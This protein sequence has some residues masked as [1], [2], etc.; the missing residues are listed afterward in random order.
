M[1]IKN[2]S[3]ACVFLFNLK[4]SFRR[5]RRP[6]FRKAQTHLTINGML[7]IICETNGNVSGLV[8]GRGG[9]HN[10]MGIK[11]HGDR[12]NNI[13]VASD[14]AAYG[15]CV[16]IL[17]R[18]GDYHWR[19]ADFHL[20]LA[21]SLR[22]FKRK[23]FRRIRRPWEKIAG[24]GLREPVR[25]CEWLILRHRETEECGLLRSLAPKAGKRIARWLG[26]RCRLDA[27]ILWCAEL[28]LSEWGTY[29]AKRKDRKFKE[30]CD[31]LTSGEM[32]DVKY[33]FIHRDAR[34]T[35]TERAA[36]CQWAEATRKA[37]AAAPATPAASTDPAVKPASAAPAKA[38]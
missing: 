5:L 10:E 26:R 19:P 31:Q 32:P 18:F 13:E 34:L 33:T 2:Y 25:L 23:T 21:E 16:A 14:F 35:D 24:A 1:D 4:W 28:N 38:P 11:R 20:D 36:V 29:N 12:G 9:D 22:W 27:P 3:R 7:R 6:S 37:Q 15:V 8:L 17:N 30:I